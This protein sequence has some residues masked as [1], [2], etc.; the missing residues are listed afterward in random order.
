MKISFSSHQ[1][2]SELSAMKFC[3]WHDSSAVEACTKCYSDTISYNG[4]TLIPNFHWIWIT[5]EKSFVKWSPVPILHWWIT[6]TKSRHIGPISW[7]QKCQITV[8]KA[9]RQ[10]KLKTEISIHVNRV[11]TRVALRYK[12]LPSAS[13]SKLWKK[14]SKKKKIHEKK[15]YHEAFNG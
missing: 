1:S 6:V 4:I 14:K 10:E 13:S 15:K 5:M 9:I 11:G 12:I 7:Q 8:E 3:T 2:C